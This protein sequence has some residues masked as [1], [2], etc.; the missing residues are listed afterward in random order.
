[1]RNDRIPMIDGDEYDFLTSWRHN[2][3]DN[4]GMRKWVKQKYNKRIR[5]QAK[6]QL[7]AE[8]RKE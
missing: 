8:E 4:H 1:M 6:R 3:A 2:L 7:E 5:R